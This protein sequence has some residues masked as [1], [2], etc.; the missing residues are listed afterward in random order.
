MHRLEKEGSEAVL[1]ADVEDPGVPK[2]VAEAV[3]D[4]T[5]GVKIL[6]HRCLE[7]GAHVEPR[8]VIADRHVFAADARRDV[9][10][11]DLLF[12][13]EFAKHVRLEEDGLSLVVGEELPDAEAA[14]PMRESIASCSTFV[15]AVE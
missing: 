4:V 3:L 7:T 11:A 1:R 14:R 12:A 15:W 10:H 8:A 5:V 6:R 13:H 2:V 9:G